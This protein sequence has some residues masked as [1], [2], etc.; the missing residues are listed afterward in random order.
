[1]LLGDSQRTIISETSSTGKLV[2]L[3]DL[4]VEGNITHPQASVTTD[5]TGWY[6][7]LGEYTSRHLTYDSS[8]FAT[9]SSLARGVA[10]L[11]TNKDLT[12]R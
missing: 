6:R 8:K 11:T 5:R 1:V 12:G 4:K 3:L 9:L 2:D 7:L 10:Q